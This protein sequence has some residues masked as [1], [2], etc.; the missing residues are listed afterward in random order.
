MKLP[1]TINFFSEISGYFISQETKEA[2]HC[3]ITGLIDKFIKYP[4]KNLENFYSPRYENIKTIFADYYER[5]YLTKNYI[6]SIV[7]RGEPKE[8]KSLYVSQS[9]H[10]LNKPKERYTIDSSENLFDLFDVHKRIIIE[11]TEGQG[12][13]TI[14][15][16]ILVEIIQKNYAK[17]IL[18]NLKELSTETSIFRQIAEM[19]SPVDKPLDEN[20]IIYFLN[21]SNTIFLFDGFDEI[22]IEKKGLISE[23][24]FDFSK[25]VDVDAKII[26]TSRPDRSLNPFNN[27]TFF[28][29]EPLDFNLTK[30]LI[31][32][33][34]NN[35]ERSNK[36]INEINKDYLVFNK[37]G[38]KKSYF[39]L[40]KNPLLLSMLCLT[41]KHNEN[42]PEGKSEYFD[43]V[44]DALYS[45]NDSMKYSNY[46]HAKTSNLNKRGFKFLLEHLGEYAYSEDKYSFTNSEFEKTIEQ[47]IDTYFVIERMT[48][49]NRLPESENIIYDLTIAI[50]MFYIVDN[51][52][53]WIHKSFSEYFFS[54]YLARQD[55]KNKL[56]KVS[57]II[58]DASK[59]S[60][61]YD[62]LDFYTEYD[63][64]F[65]EKQFVAP[66][67]NN[68]ITYYEKSYIHN[69][70]KL[71]DT[72][73]ID[74]KKTLDFL[75]DTIK[76]YIRHKAEEYCITSIVTFKKDDFN[77]LLSYLKY[78]NFDIFLNNIS[79]KVDVVGSLNCPCGVYQLN[80]DPNNPMNTKNNIIPLIDSIFFS[81]ASFDYK[82]SP[83]NSILDYKKCK[84][85]YEEIKE[86]E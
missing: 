81:K 49:D 58:R 20:S 54:R 67:L 14:L 23:K 4:I 8:L 18:I 5:E 83:I 76:V 55:E 15:K 16:Y 19:V 60:N 74:I 3:L 46:C 9:I 77:D 10:P 28:R 63:K 64:N 56:A 32:H 70:F 21:D 50:P 12:K 38:T 71:I 79:G 31:R 73:Y 66:F 41:F 2:T 53:T 80:D 24:L 72:F 42:I 29:I 25:K 69:N 57:K 37:K 17:P 39:Q 52:Y 47:I 6:S 45:E 36:L 59:M 27:F 35:S 86:T 62:I 34:E 75:I 33:Y 26:I 13:S 40:L 7:F 30:K 43:Q 82:L 68:Y 1:N 22:E 11:D 51:K 65:F 78:R 48:L 85:V 44:F 61:A 84:R